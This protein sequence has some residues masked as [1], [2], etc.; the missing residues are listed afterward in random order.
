M[1]Q[2]IC[3]APAWGPGPGGGVGVGRVLWGGGGA[4]T[5][6]QRGVKSTTS[7]QDVEESK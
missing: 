6:P 1:H 2:S 5:R 7:K 3:A 4:Q